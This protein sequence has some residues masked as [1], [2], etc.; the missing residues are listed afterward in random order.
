LETP[1]V[2]AE[3]LWKIDAEIAI[4]RVRKKTKFAGSEQMSTPSERSVAHMQNATQKQSGKTEGKRGDAKGSDEGLRAH[5][6]AH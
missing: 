3:F 4:L 5:A 2:A 6:P 1:S